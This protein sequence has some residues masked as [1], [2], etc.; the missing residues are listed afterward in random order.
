MRLTK[1]EK[2]VEDE[3][4]KENR[5]MNREM[6]RRN[7]GELEGIKKDKR[8]DKGREGGGGRQKVEEEKKDI[9]EERGGAGAA[10]GGTHLVEGLHQPLVVGDVL[11]LVQEP[12]VDLGQ[13]VQLVHCVAVTQRRRQDE[14]ALV[15][16]HLQLLKNSSGKRC[17]KEGQSVSQG[18]EVGGVRAE[19]AL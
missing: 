17:L 10:A 18:E 12:A 5:R 13:L 4:R 2:Q 8:V 19:F 9:K 1:K 11:H 16:R 14:D 6:N 15:C 7:L 3:K